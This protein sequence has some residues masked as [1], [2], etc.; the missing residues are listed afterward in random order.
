MWN[1]TFSHIYEHVKHL[2]FRGLTLSGK[3]TRPCRVDLIF[4]KNLKIDQEGNFRKIF[5]WNNY[6]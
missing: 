4:E 5:D 6:L 2:K 1:E 3:I